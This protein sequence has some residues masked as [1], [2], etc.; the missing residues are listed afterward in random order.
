AR[1]RTASGPSAASA[2]AIVFQA[3]AAL[4][5]G[6]GVGRF[7]YTPILPL[8]R[9]QAGLS[10]GFAG[11]LAT[12]NYI[13]YLGGALAGILVPALLRSART[14]RASLLALVASLALMPVSHVGAAWFALRLVAGVA[15]ALVFMIAVSAML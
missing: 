14:L 5:A 7:V 11:T 10:A 12:A 4:A 15:S 8:M 6:I 13:G 9:D 2:W 1:R 3:G